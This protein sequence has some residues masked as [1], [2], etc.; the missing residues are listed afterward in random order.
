MCMSVGITVM[1]N[2]N[3]LLLRFSSCRGWWLREFPRRTGAMT[4]E[5]WR[6]NSAGLF[7][8]VVSMVYMYVFYGGGLWQEETYVYIIKV[9][10]VPSLWRL[11]FER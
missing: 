3:T 6:D 4:K 11:P 1:S 7:C 9:C 5:Q 10:G 2:M 8:L